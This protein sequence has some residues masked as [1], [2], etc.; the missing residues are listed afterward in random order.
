MQSII[1]PV[2]PPLPLANLVVDERGYSEQVKDAAAISPGVA[3]PVL[4]LA[5][6]VEPVHLCTHIYTLTQV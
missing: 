1:G 2:Q 6:V 3:V 5:L 4:V